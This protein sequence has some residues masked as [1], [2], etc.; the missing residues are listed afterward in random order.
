M[1]SQK[2]KPARV[3]HEAIHP[4]Q[5]VTLNDREQPMLAKFSVLVETLAFFLVAELYANDL[6]AFVNSPCETSQA[7]GLCLQTIPS[8]SHR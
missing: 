5:R 4:T 3:I 2:T 1:L 8:T 7:S 6:M